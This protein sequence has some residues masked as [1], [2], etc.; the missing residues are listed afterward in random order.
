MPSQPSRAMHPLSVL[1]DESR[2]LRER[3]QAVA[4]LP[5]AQRELVRDELAALDALLSDNP[6]QGFEP[7]SEPQRSFIQARTPIVAAFAGNRFGKTTSLVVKALVEC[8][9]SEC[10][11]APLR[12]AKIW[13]KERAPSGTFGRIVVP[14]F[15]TTLEGVVIPA[16][17]QWAPQH[18]LRGGDFDKAWDKQR[19]MI[20]FRNGSWIQ[21]MT[22]EQDQNKFGGAALHFVGYDEPPPKNIREECR[23]RLVD[24][25][26]FEMFALTPLEGAG[27]MRKVIWRR[28][29][30]EHVT[31]ITGS[32]HDNPLLNEDE[33]ERAL[34]E[35]E[36]GDIRRRSREFGEFV[37]FGSNLLYPDFDRCGVAP[38]SLKHVQQLEIVV[39]IDP[40][41]RNTAIV[42]GGFDSENAALIFDEAL[43]QS[44]VP[45]DYAA[46]IRQTAQEW[47]IPLDRIQFVID[48]S[49]RNR[50]LVDAQNVQSVL[51]AE[52][53]YCSSGFNAVEAGIQQVRNR[54]AT[55]GLYVSRKCV[56]LFDEADDY[57]TDARDDGEFHVVKENDHR[58]D[59][60]RYLLTARLW[61]QRPE[62]AHPPVRDMT[63]S[64]PPS[65]PAEYAPSTGSLT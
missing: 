27:W 13:T 64:W 4:L 14:D 65:R 34:G 51:A 56:G 63:Q 60:L 53:I 40:G 28:R 52:G 26:G 18:Q 49:A 59:A 29:D 12:A 39:G 41:I 24:F 44:K 9:D 54:L 37:E 46:S 55:E 1:A 8:V 2:S 11:P 45:K 30:S 15:G 23:W 58:L 19:R 31:V 21:L 48:P 3:I 20:S 62:P 50:S 42:W 16:L 35:F 38:P 17:R 5:E 10:L 47:G 32:I 25:G 6:L 61:F 57:R 36:E 7:H 33:R 43:L 22:Y